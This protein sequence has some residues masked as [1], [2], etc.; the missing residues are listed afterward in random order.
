M[1]SKLRKAVPCFKD[2]FEAVNEMT[3]EWGD[4]LES[5]MHDCW[6]E[7]MEECM[8]PVADAVYV[9]D[10]QWVDES[11]GAGAVAMERFWDI[12]KEIYWKGGMFFFSI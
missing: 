5:D 10:P 2:Q 8:L 4:R 7:W 3:Q 1:L 11:K 6:R 12:A 9:I